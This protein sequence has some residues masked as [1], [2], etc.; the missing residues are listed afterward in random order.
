MQFADL[1]DA[2]GTCLDLFGAGIIAFGAV[3]VF[4]WRP[5]G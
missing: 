2:V 3:V 5:S 4:A 1:V